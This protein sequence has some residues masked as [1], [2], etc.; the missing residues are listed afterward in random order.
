M[1]DFMRKVLSELDGILANENGAAHRLG[2]AV[3]VVLH[4]REQLATRNPDDLAKH[5]REVSENAKLPLA[6]C[7]ASGDARK[8]AELFIAS[9]DSL[10][11]QTLGHMN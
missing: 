10:Y 11:R 4:W 2:L 1:T 9:V 8:L 7:E 5:I 3:P 6:E